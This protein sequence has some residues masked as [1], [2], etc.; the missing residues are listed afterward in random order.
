MSIPIP[1]LPSIVLSSRVSHCVKCGDTLNPNLPFNAPLVCVNCG[2]EMDMN[3]PEVEEDE[4]T[5]EKFQKCVMCKKFKDQKT[6]YKINEN[7][8]RY[9]HTC[10]QCCDKQNLRE[11]KR[12]DSLKRPREDIVNNM[13]CD[14]FITSTNEDMNKKIKLDEEGK[15]EIAVINLLTD[16]LTSLNNNNNPNKVY[17][18][19]IKEAF[20]NEVKTKCA[21]Y[22]KDFKPF[23]KHL[24][25]QCIQW[26]PHSDFDSTWPFICTECVQKVHE[27]EEESQVRIKLRWQT[28]YYKRENHIKG[29]EKK[30]AVLNE[31]HKLYRITTALKFGICMKE[32]PHF[33]IAAHV[34][35]FLLKA[36]EIYQEYPI[37]CL[38]HLETHLASNVVIQHYNVEDPRVKLVKDVSFTSRMTDWLIENCRKPLI[39]Q[40]VTGI[41]NECKRKTWHVYELDED[42]DENIV[43]VHKLDMHRKKKQCIGYIVDY[44][45]RYVCSNPECRMLYLLHPENDITQQPCCLD[46]SVVSKFT[47]KGLRWAYQISTEDLELLGMQHREYDL[48]DNLGEED[49]ILRL[50]DQCNHDSEFGQHERDIFNPITNTKEQITVF[51]CSKCQSDWY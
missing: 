40:K 29:Q 49:L 7:H 1:I 25:F 16:S 4:E 17:N 13:I 28:S 15:K 34:F 2:S 24:C 22:F 9:Y 51:S 6:D 11:Q 30:L 23:T 8:A 21:I 35:A 26:L 36:G 38:S 44:R 10:I 50:E 33:G 18:G 20:F 39:Y 3:K 47:S 19:S 31:A 32:N 45:P 43:E 5:G 48:K 46:C 27:M 37:C 12:R 14:Q 41:K 42:N